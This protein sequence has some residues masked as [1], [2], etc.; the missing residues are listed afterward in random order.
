MI[1]LCIFDLDGTVLDTVTTIA[2]YVNT[3]LENNSIEPIEVEQFKYLAGRGMA[4][5]IRDSLNFRNCYSDALFEKV[6]N[7]YNKAYNADVTYKT[8]I[9]DGLKEVLDAIKAL[10]IPMAIVSNKP[11]FATKTVVNKLYGE[12][13]FEFV[14]ARREKDKL[15]LGNLFIVGGVLMVIAIVTAVLVV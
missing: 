9:F 10:G 3:A 12:G 14:T 5:L 7:E 4:S 11:D 1:K 8:T 15:P 13:Y 2:H 6:L